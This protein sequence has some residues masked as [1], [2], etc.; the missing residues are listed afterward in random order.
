MPEEEENEPDVR[1]TGMLVHRLTFQ[2]RLCFVAVSVCPVGI[3][4][5]FEANGHTGTGELCAWGKWKMSGS[6]TKTLW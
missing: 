3:W 2:C 5:Q 1:L 4:A 6:Y